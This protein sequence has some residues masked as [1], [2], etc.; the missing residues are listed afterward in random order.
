MQIGTCQAHLPP[1]SMEIEPGAAG[2]ADLQ[3]PLSEFRVETEV[4]CAPGNLVTGL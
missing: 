4:L 3:Q 2:A 1:A